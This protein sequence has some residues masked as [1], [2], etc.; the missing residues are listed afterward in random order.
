L[1]DAR[2]TDATRE[3]GMENQAANALGLSLV[4][5]I[6]AKYLGASKRLAEAAVAK[7]EQKHGGRFYKPR[8]SEES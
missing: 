3:E 8:G 7:L 2:W 1:V 4:A 5:S 6:L